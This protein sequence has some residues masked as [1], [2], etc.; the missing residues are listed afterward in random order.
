MNTKQLL[1]EAIELMLRAKVEIEHLQIDEKRV[2]WL[3]GTNPRLFSREAI[4]KSM[5]TRPL[6]E[7]RA[8]L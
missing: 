8:Y 4:D 2:D 7:K 5:Q 1:D 3:A 6:L